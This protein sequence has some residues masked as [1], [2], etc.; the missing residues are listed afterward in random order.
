M[1]TPKSEIQVLAE[2]QAYYH[3][4]EKLIK[5]THKES[6][7]SIG[8]PK[9]NM[10]QENRIALR[11]K[12]VKQLVSQGHQI[13]LEAGAGVLAGFSDYQYSEAGAKIMYSADQLYKESKIILKI[14]P[15]VIAEIDRMN[16]RTT[17]ISTLAINTLKPD[18]ILALNRK[19]ITAITCELFEDRVGGLPFVRAMSEITGSVV[20][21]IAGEYLSGHNGGRGMILGSITGV[22]P[23]KVVII[24]AGAVAEYAARAAIGMGASVRVFDNHLYK[25]RRLKQTLA[26]FQL[27]TAPIDSSTLG[28]TLQTTDVTIGA[29]RADGVSTP[30]VVTEEMVAK[31]QPGS[32]IIDVSIDQGGCFETSRLTTHQKPIFRKY[33][34]IHYCVPNIP[35]RVAN[36]A[37]TAF[38]NMFTPILIRMSEYGG[39]DD[40]IF[41]NAKFFSGVYCYNGE[42]TNRAIGNKFGMRYRDLG[43]IAAASQ[44]RKI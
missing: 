21:T 28:H 37:S 42:L 34:V 31:M 3:P 15:P 29:L 23:T 7:L 10:R 26:N 11:P 43:L 5:I 25:L 41:Q 32:V 35:S 14:A 16:P 36:T 44:R 22:T 24:G 6:H 4:Q 18:M 27:Y 20:M 19:R 40:M 9:E 30:C 13:C 2:N 12:A 38:S 8:L 33:D 17:V 39:I 1:S